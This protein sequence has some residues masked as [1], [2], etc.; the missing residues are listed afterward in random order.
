MHRKLWHECRG[1][2]E[3]LIYWGWLEGDLGY[4]LSQRYELVNLG[5]LV[6]HDFYHLEHA[7]QR[8]PG[9]SKRLN[10]QQHSDH[11][12][13]ANNDRWGLGGCQLELQPYPAN[14]GLCQPPDPQGKVQPGAMFRGLWALPGSL[15]FA[16]AEPWTMKDLP[17]RKLCKKLLG[18]LQASHHKAHS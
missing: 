9:N 11:V 7:Q 8:V 14:G 5:P 1:Y 17:K 6:G 3:R 13:A 2:D 4:R 16:M 12:Y 18:V 10:K 15:A